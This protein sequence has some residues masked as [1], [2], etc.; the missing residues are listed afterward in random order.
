MDYVRRST[1]V[2]VS[3]SLERQEAVPVPQGDT[4]YMAVDM[5]VLLGIV[6]T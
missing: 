3:R 1:T 5:S 2:T 6:L 4:Y